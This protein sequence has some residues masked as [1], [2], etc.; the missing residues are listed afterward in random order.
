MSKVF[1]FGIDGAFPEYIFGEWLED[2]PN[3][4]KL[5]SGG[6]YAKMNS[7]IPPLS[8][9]AWTSIFTGEPPVETGIFEYVYRKN[10]C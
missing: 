1:V 9:T 4:K 6:S 7:T 5:I 10:E 8:A 2:L 3:L